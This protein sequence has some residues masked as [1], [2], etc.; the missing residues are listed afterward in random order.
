[1]A[2]GEPLPLAVLAAWECVLCPL[3]LLPPRSRVTKMSTGKQRRL[4][5]GGGSAGGRT[6]GAA[7]YSALC[8][9][10]RGSSTK[11]RRKHC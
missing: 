1:M 4:T 5:A 6:F 2:A 11:R 7:L 9:E 10:T 3:T 8:W